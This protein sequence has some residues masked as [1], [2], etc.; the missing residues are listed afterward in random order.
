MFEWTDQDWKGVAPE[1]QVLYEMHIGSPGRVAD[2]CHS[3]DLRQ[4]R[5]A[6]PRCYYAESSRNS[7]PALHAHC[8]R[9]R[10]AEGRASLTLRQGRLRHR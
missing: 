2:R 4:L 1:G 9:E 7:P 5:R 3:A 8:R 10:T 6:H